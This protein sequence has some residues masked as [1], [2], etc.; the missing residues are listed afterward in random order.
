MM[1]SVTTW[2]VLL[3][4]GFESHSKDS[5]LFLTFNLSMICVIQFRQR[6]YDFPDRNH[7]DE[8]NIIFRRILYFLYC[9]L[10]S[11]LSL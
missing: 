6:G 9:M 8:R 1:S 4:S 3:L 5:V 10:D 11:G 7:F 2:F